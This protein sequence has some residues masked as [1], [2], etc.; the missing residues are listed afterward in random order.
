MTKTR[1]TIGLLTAD[2]DFLAGRIADRLAQLAVPLRAAIVDSKAVSAK[3][4]AIF[5]QR[6]DGRLPPVPLADIVPDL[7]RI[8]VGSH[9]DRETIDLIHRLE[10]DLL[11]NAGTPRIL[12]Q[13]LLDAV[14]NGVLNCHPG[15]LP[16]FR[17]C[18]CVEWAIYLDRPVG[19]TV[20]LMT[21]GIDEGPVITR[22]SVP[23][24]V[25]A[26]YVDIRVATYLAGIEL[27]ASATADIFFGDRH[28]ASFEPQTG[29]RYF[30]V[31]DDDKLAAVHAKLA[32]GG[33]RP[34]V[35]R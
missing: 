22:A 2:G 18:C 5:Q 25:G 29:G 35:F 15:L 20:H 8:N 6:T 14:P 16:D 24:F 12:R 7:P 11:V 19:N 23:V 10:I 4:A 21:A 34:T 31:I 26:T 3:D 9:N 28:P 13:P 30:K 32:D 1:P 17:G 27:L 33:Y